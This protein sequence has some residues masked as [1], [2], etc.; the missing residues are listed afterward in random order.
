MIFCDMDGVLVNFDCGCKRQLGKLPHMFERTE[1]WEKVLNTKDY[2][3]N[4]DKKS[5]A[6]ELIEFLSHHEFCILTGI[7]TI[8]YDKAESE[9]K[10]WLKKHYRI[11][12]NV[13][14]CLSKDK[15]LYGKKLDILID[16]FEKNINC[17]EEMGGIGILHT[18]TEE[19][20]K[21]LRELGYK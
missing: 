14:C 1:L 19:T 7:P 20:L 13:I 12:K 18:T 16:D 21:K 15:P 11:E 3:Y 2:W 8:G 5:D 9:K 10:R 4:L 6:D 17:W